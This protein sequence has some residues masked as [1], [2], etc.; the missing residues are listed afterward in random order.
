M[1]PNSG[2]RFSEKRSCPSNKL[3]R[4][5]DT[6]KSH[7]ALVATEQPVRAELDARLQENAVVV[8][9]PV[10]DLRHCRDTH[11]MILEMSVAVRLHVPVAAAEPDAHQIIHA[12]GQKAVDLV[13]PAVA[14]LRHRAGEIAG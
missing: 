13:A 14:V 4:D 10:H 1:I 5:D 3:E 8:G 9:L 11:D 12:I 7:P 6:K 2:K